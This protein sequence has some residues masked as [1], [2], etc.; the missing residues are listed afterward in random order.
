MYRMVPYTTHETTN[1]F[2]PSI[3]CT[4]SHCRG[5]SFNASIKRLARAWMQCTEACEDKIK[6]QIVSRNVADHLGYF[7]QWSKCWHSGV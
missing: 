4:G 6:K 5:V 1:I 3:S 7:Y 2:Q